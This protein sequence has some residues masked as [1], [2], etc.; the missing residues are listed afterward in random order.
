MTYIHIIVNLFK[1]H[2][3]ESYIDQLT[4]SA[5]KLAT[6]VLVK[7]GWFVTK[8]FRSKDYLSLVWAFKKLFKRVSIIYFIKFCFKV[9]N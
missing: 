8:V 7:G 6:E 4:L 3:F 5:L 1:Q 2:C 9:F